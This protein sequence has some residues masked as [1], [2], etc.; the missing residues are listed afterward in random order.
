MTASAATHKKIASLKA[1][2]RHHNYRYHVLDDPEIPDVEYDRLMRQLQALEKANPDLITDD[3]PTQ[4]VGDKPIAAFG[5]VKH[6]VPM[7]SLENAFSAEEL[8]DFH[9]RVAERLELEDA[10]DSLLYAAEPKLDGAAVSLLYEAGRLVRAATRGDGTTGEDITHNVRTIESVP[11]RLIGEGYP[12]TLEV[13]GEVFMPKAGFEAYN[14]KARAAGE[15][16]FVNPRNAAAG[17]LRQLDPKLTAE[18]PLD[19][20]VYSVG[21]VA[22]GDLPE[23]HS[24]MLD[25][26][27]NWGLKTCPERRVVTGVEGCLSF[28]EAIGAKRDSLG[29]EIDGVVYKVNNLL[30]QRELGFVSRAPRWAIAHKFPAQEELTTVEGIEFQVG[31]TGALT[32][33]ARLKPVFVGGVTVSNATLHNIDELHRK[34]VRVGDTVTIRRAGDVIP[35][36]VGVIATRRPQG[37]RR[38]QLP[39]TCPVCGSAVARDDG[40]AVA[41]CTGGLYCSAQRANSLK[42]FVSRKALDIEGLGSKL[43]DQLV[44]VDRINTP[45]DIFRLDKD[46]LAA[47]ERMGEKS[48]ENLLSSIESSRSTTLARFLFALGIREVGEATAAALA[49]HFGK[50]E[51]IIE[52][53]EE[54]LLSVN[55]V[56]PVVAS[57]I[58]AFFD[59]PHNRDV[60]AALQNLGVHW[61]ET[62]PQQNPTDGPLSGKTFVL[63]G[64]L[65]GMTRDEAKQKIQAAG[66]KVTGSVSKKTDFVVFGERPGSKLAKAQKLE[67]GTLDEEQFEKL[68]AGQ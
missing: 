34:D 28:Y 1:Q 22:G 46:E 65:S 9:R 4:R 30:Q 6:Q 67:V 10:A 14:E 18:R 33:V 17:S 13:R 37:S 64:T 20:Y 31:R 66:G 11:L 59:E 42:H 58:R 2:I 43:I 41:R 24:E 25:Q 16:T 27:E 29:Y 35:E 56:G 39:K 15:K 38:I 12:S 21:R 68:L 36:V 45:A 51:S 5:T 23:S 61:S 53:R 40:E 8:R 48:A 49:A 3:S 19:M 54:D 50:L 60:I 47:M 52:A 55:D 32:P 26:L 62:E 63:T 7:L 57:R 44:S